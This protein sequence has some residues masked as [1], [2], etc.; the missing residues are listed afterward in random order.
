MKEFIQEW[1]NT[2]FVLLKQRGF[3]EIEIAKAAWLAGSLYE[4]KKQDAQNIASDVFE[5]IQDLDLMLNN[6]TI[7]SEYETSVSNQKEPTA[8][9]V[10]SLEILNG[11]KIKNEI[12]LFI[13][14]DKNN[15]K[16]FLEKIK[17]P[18]I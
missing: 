10:E 5:E 2:T 6:V 3:N 9:S 14:E 8:F 16:D 1:F 12:L 15:V 7:K 4:K 11:L 18:R 17:I 13:L